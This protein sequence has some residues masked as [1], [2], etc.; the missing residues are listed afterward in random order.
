M[1]EILKWACLNGA[2]FLAKDDIL[3][4]ISEGKKPGIVLVKNIDAD[5]NVT[6]E[7]VS[8]RVI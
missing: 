7:S 1:S 5:G 8:E 3:G 6:K 2:R 4:S